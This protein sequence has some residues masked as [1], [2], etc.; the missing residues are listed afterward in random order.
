MFDREFELKAIEDGVLAKRPMIVV[1]GIRRIGKTSLINVAMNELDIPSV[2]LDCRAL[3]S[4]YTRADLYRLLSNALSSSLDKLRDVL[5]RISGISIMGNVVEIHWRGRRYVSLAELFD[6]LNERRIIIV[7]DEAQ[8]LR[9]PLSG[10]VKNA[11]AHAYDFDDNVTFILSGSEVGL[12]YDF[13]GVE[14]PN[15]PLYGR[16]FIE[17]KVN[18]FIKDQSMEF[19]RAGFREV[20]VVVPENELERMVNAVDGIPGWLAYMGNQYIRSIRDVDA[21]FEMAVREALNEL[22]GLV[23]SRERVSGIAG[24]RLAIALRCIA[25]GSDSW[26]KLERCIEEAEG[27]TISPSVL[28]NIVRNLERLSIVRNYEFQDPVYREAARRLRP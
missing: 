23:R 8:R 18:R 10:E 14:D 17:V 7:L 9:G 27:S 3:R 24:R 12:L 28:G 13:L 26:G 19:L 2:I 16:Y 20:G 4:N 1:T 11:I 15:S 22:E 6:R 21:V 25:T 5:S